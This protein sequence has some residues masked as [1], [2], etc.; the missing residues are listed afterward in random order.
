MKRSLLL[1][2]LTAFLGLTAMACEED[3]CINKN[4]SDC[5]M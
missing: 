3:T 2:V 5:Y 4:K 1:A